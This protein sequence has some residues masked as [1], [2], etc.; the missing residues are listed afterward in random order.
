MYEVSREWGAY[1]TR[2]FSASAGSNGSSKQRM[3]IDESH[4][5][6]TISR[7]KSRRSF[8]VLSLSAFEFRQERQ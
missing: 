3:L 5:R 4:E 8:H 7:G 2:W 6:E 1:V